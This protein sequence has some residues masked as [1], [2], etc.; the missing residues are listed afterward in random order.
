MKFY[1]Y[2]RFI[3]FII[4]DV[5]RKISLLQKILKIKFFKIEEWKIFFLKN[6]AKFFIKGWGCEIYNIFTLIFLHIIIFT[7]FIQIKS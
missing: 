1:N 5:V 7:I 6:W 2:N 4:G 3:Y